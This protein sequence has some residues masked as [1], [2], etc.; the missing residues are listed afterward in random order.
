MR[1][2]YDLSAMKPR[3]NPYAK[4]LK[5]QVTIRLGEDVLA[6]FKDMSAE[7]GVP[8]QRLIDLYLRDCVEHARRISIRWDEQPDAG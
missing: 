3:A 8:Y 7:T 5:K 4:R 2:E 1:D 6:Y